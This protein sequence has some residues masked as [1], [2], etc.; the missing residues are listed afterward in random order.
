MYN[1]NAAYDF[2]PLR[3]ENHKEGKVLKLPGKSQRKIQKNR[4]LKMFMGSVFSVFLVSAGCGFLFI[5][6]QSKFAECIDKVSKA[7]KELDQIQSENTS[8]LLSKE[9]LKASQ[10]YKD[11]ENAK[12]EI[13]KITGE[14]LAAV[15]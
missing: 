8:M 9:S 3:K 6:E 10:N 11:L 12:V 1:R 5:S 7:S 13:V 2:T 15:K 14:D 4:A